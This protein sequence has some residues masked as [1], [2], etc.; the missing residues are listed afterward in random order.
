MKYQTQLL[1][2]ELPIYENLY[3]VKGMKYLTFLIS[4]MEV[5]RP[6]ALNLK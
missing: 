5:R 3:D 6:F 1:V 4:R 2:T